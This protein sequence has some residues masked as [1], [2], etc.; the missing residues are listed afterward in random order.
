MPRVDQTKVQLVFL[1]SA[2][3]VGIDKNTFESSL[4]LLNQSWI[5]IIYDQEMLIWGI[6]PLDVCTY[7]H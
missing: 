7:R 5:C 3:R 1:H 4:E 2:G 6:Q